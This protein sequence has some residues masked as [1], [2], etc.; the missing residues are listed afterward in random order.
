M[1]LIVFIIMLIIAY[2]EKT[3]SSAS[4]DLSYGT[5]YLLKARGYVMCY[6]LFRLETVSA[7]DEYA[8]QVEL[9]FRIQL[10]WFDKKFFNATLDQSPKKLNSLFI[11]HLKLI[12]QPC[13]RIRNLF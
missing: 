6:V 9:I 4:F 11:K 10:S 2:C 3:D 13:I 1:K 5:D 7:V 12:V 8:Q